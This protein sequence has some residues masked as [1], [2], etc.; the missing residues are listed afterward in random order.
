MFCVF[1]SLVFIV[2]S[3]WLPP[4]G[5]EEE[6]M[7][8]ER[9]TGLIEGLNTSSE[10]R[11]RILEMIYTEL[12]GPDGRQMQE[13]LRD[14]LTRNNTVILQGVVEAMA[15]LGDPRDVASLDALLA[16]S[17]KLE[18]KVLVIR[19][20]PTFC[21]Q[22]ER[23]R[24]N[25]IHYAGGYDRV[26][27]AS[28]LEPLRRPPLTR[29]G[30]LDPDLERLRVAIVRSLAAQFDPVGAALKYIDDLLYSQAA[31]KAVANFV[32]KALGNDPSR[33]ARIWAEQGKDMELLVPDELEEI[34]LAA[35]TSLSDMGAEGLPEVIEAFRYLRTVPG[36]ILQQAVYDTMATMCRSAFS[37]F[38]TLSGLQFSAEEAA[39]AE[40]WRER[41]NQ[42]AANLAA[43][44]AKCAEE[45]LLEDSDAGVFVSI[46]SALGAALSYPAALPDTGGR[47]AGVR[48]NGLDRLEFL[49][50]HP[51]LSREKRSAVAAAL[52]EVGA[53]R[54]VSA[55]ASIIDSP[56][57]SPEYGNAGARFAESVIDALRTVATG[58]REGRNAAREALLAL[59]AEKRMYP[60][61]RAGAPEVGLAH[62]VLWRLQRLVRSNDSQL[63]A[64]IWRERLNW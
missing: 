3:L 1:L 62:M 55:L 4:A 36:N 21:L 22:S 14:S 61:L 51:D 47:L 60:A 46:V 8:A 32:G 17:D 13:L 53:A 40:G 11:S 54:S 2:A 7:R 25:Y 45:K 5:A 50:M 64:S 27:E 15:M 23:A 34:R 10:R 57:C 26:P 35:L 58:D 9:F 49:L 19:L 28:L 59:L 33:W 41:R 16:T 42:S 20:L 39:G 56:Y 43:F 37:S 18:V 12:R 63:E 6:N 31:R 48:E 38:E 52:G 29:R 30:R 44:T 24:F